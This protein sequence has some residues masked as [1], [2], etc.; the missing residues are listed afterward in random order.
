MV[1]M[2]TG[3]IA[4]LAIVVFLGEYAV[5]INTLPLWVII[6]GVCAM[7]V[8]DYVK[9]IKAHRELEDKRESDSD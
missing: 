2:I 9:S 7:M 6:C 8:Y 1:N 3:A 4:V 5:T